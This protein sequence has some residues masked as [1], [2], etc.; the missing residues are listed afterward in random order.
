M[1]NTLDHQVDG[2]HYKDMLLQP[3]QIIE[4]LRLDYFHGAVLKYLLRWQVKDGVIDLDKIIHYVEHIKQLALS[5]HYGDQFKATKP[6]P[7]VYVSPIQNWND[8]KW[9]VVCQRYA[10]SLFDKESKDYEHDGLILFN[11]NH[12]IA[13]QKISKASSRKTAKGSK[14]LT[15]ARSIKKV[16]LDTFNKKYPKKGML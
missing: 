4:Q 11:T 8:I 14:R 6:D 12:P 3:W 13:K 9:N 15:K 7:D 16:S 2:D 5:G 10:D 1:H